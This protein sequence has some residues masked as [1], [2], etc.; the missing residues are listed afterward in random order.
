[1]VASLEKEGMGYLASLCL[2]TPHKT[3]AIDSKEDK[4]TGVGVTWIE[5]VE[6]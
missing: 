2:Q 5:I 1:M 6:Q 3:R 4:D